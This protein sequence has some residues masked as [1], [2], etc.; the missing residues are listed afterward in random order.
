MLSRFQNFHLWKHLPYKNFR[1]HFTN[2]DPPPT[3]VQK[4]NTPP[5][6]CTNVAPPINVCT[7]VDPPP[8]TFVQTLTPPLNVCTKK[9]IFTKN[10]QNQIFSPGKWSEPENFQKKKIFTLEP[11]WAPGSGQPWDLAIFGPGGP[12]KVKKV[13]FFKKKSNFFFDPKWPELVG[14]GQKSEFWAN[15][16][17]YRCP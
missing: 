15:F 3:F 5:N 9:K 12:K 16:F 13:T 4:L 10:D 6:H 8:S 11:P 7:N 14:T 2:V 1:D 17:F